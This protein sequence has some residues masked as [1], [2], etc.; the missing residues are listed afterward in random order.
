MQS[1]SR[2]V[3]FKDVSIDY[4]KFDRRVSWRKC[5]DGET[6]VD[7]EDQSTDVYFIVTGEVRVLLRTASGKEVILADLKAGEF[8]G[9]LAAIDGIPRS[10]NVTALT[11]ADLCI[12]PAAV[13]REILFSCQAACDKVLKL[14]AH[15]VRDG[16]TRLAE[17]SIFDLRHRL[18]SEL[19]RMSHPRPGHPGEKVVSPPP[20]HHVMASRIGCRREQVT[21]EL[22]VMASEG[23]IEKT[24]GAL[25]LIK[26]SVLEARLTLAMAEGD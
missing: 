24:R 19:L 18:Y 17:M 1:L 9:E 25:V 11:K 23:L 3:F 12:M 20:F 14:L 6:L 22:S 21:R 8:F 16:N 7:F 10:A 4:E 2:L 15:R 13:F 5:D 26:P